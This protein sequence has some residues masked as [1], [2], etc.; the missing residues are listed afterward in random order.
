MQ[1]APVRPEYRVLIV[2]DEPDVLTVTRM[3][4]R[5]VSHA[6]R[7]LRL[8]TAASGAEAVR[9]V[10]ADPDI[11]LVFMDVV[12]ES[13][14][15]GLEACRAIR[16]QLGNRLV[17]LVVRTGQPG[18]VPERETIEA[19]DID[20]YLAKAEITS[21]RLYSTVRT[22]LRAYDQLWQLERQRRLLTAV[23]DC[24]AQLHSFQPI[25]QILGRVLAAAQVVCP[26][27]L[28]VLALE[29]A[30]AGGDR[31]RFFLHQGS[32]AS[33]ATADAVRME[34]VR[35]RAEGQLHEPAAAAGGWAVPLTVPRAL[36]DGWLFVREPSPDEFARQALAVLLEHAGNL[37][38]STLSEQLLRAQQGSDPHAQ[39][40]V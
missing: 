26:C 29:A 19:Y 2:D 30:S 9:M 6:G 16:E 22:A 24:V 36:A 10:A 17:R 31:Q 14:N 33:Y 5:T 11:A 32:E 23:H 18:T 4:L 34:L 27:P 39:W 37:V 35:F 25:E 3:S 13:S 7:P 20:G 38:Y 28:A 12:M 1:S 40:I 15:A 21:S 8:L